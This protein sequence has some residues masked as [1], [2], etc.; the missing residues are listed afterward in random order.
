MSKFERTYALVDYNQIRHN[1]LEMKKCVPADVKVLAVVKAD[2]YGHGVEETC[3]VLNDFADFFAVATIDE[4]IDIRAI[5]GIPYEKRILI[6]GYVSPIDY[7]NLLEL[8]ITPV[9]YNY[10]DAV[11][12]NEVAAS[13][14]EIATIHLGVDTGMSRIG[15]QCDEKD[16]AIANR[17]FDLS[18]IHVEG[19][20][21]HFSKADETDPTFT[22]VQNE[23]FEKFL[24]G[25]KKKLEI[26]HIC[27]SAGIV[28]YDI[29][30]HDMVRAGITMY[31]YPPSD[32]V[33]MSKV[34]IAPALSWHA[35]VAHIKELEPGRIISYGGTF[36]VK[37]PMKVAT[38]T[39][40]YADG[41]PRALSNKGKMIINGAYAPILGRVCMDQTM[42]D[43]T[44]IPD[45]ALEDD[46]VLIGSQG[47][48][49]ITADDIAKLTG[50]IS[51]EVVC[52]ISK[53][54]KRIA[55]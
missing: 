30:R 29:Y 46:V 4:A 27:N 25:L 40:G 2:A 44:D 19:A 22:E 32:E 43:V 12:L 5:R 39:I 14:D 55:K 8:N 35:H 36:E 54:V 26:T 17:I 34:S 51:Y 9:I 45:V 11:K 33:D 23:N 24:N 15:F 7:H 31:G 53:R 3:K 21:S 1:F 47:D 42:V 41:Y 48:K 38:V 6:L 52:D 37:K 50:T 20:F 13:C 10:D 28:G 18:N 49:S 16:I